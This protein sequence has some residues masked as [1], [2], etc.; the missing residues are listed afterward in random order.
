MEFETDRL[1]GVGSLKLVADVDGNQF[2]DDSLT[3]TYAEDPDIK[4]INPAVTLVRLVRLGQNKSSFMS[5]E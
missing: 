2:S 5:T 1:E 4:M 3:F